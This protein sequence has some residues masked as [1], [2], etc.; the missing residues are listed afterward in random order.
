MGTPASNNWAFL[1][2]SAF[3]SL[4]KYS[5][6][7]MC[8]VHFNLLTQCIIIVF[9][10]CIPMMTITSLPVARDFLLTVWNREDPPKISHTQEDKDTLSCLRPQT[11]A[12]THIRH[13]LWPISFCKYPCARAQ[14]AVSL[15]SHLPFDHNLRDIWLEF[16][17]SLILSRDLSKLSPALFSWAMQNKTETKNTISARLMFKY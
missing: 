9:P 15:Q 14:N 4:W 17:L 7:H 8:Y 6:K 11:Q 3:K 12:C 2:L 16:T 5:G 10:L 13:C 1:Q